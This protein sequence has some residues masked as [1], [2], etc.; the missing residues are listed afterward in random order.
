MLNLVGLDPRTWIRL[1]DAERSARP[2][3]PAE[4]AVAPAPA[5][6]LPLLTTRIPA[7]CC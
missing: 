2:Q 7:P 6:V 1:H 5:V 3:R 4:P